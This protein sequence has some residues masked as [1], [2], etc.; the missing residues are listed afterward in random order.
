MTLNLENPES[1]LALITGGSGG[2][3]EY[4]AYEIAADGFDLVLVARTESELERVAAAAR[5]RFG[6]NVSILVFDLEEDGAADALADALGQ[7]RLVPDLVVNNAGFGLLGRAEKLS[8]E[9]QLRMI[10]LNIKVLTDLSLRYVPAM[11]KKGSGGIINVASVAGFLPGPYMSVYYAT[12]AFVNS[13]SQG[14]AYEL[15]GAGITVSSVCPGPT[16]TKFQERAGMIGRP[17]E[18]I[19][20]MM[21]AEEVAR[22]GY[23]G[24]KAGKR[25][26][27]TGAMNTL[28]SMAPR[29]MPRGFLLLVVSKLQR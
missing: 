21:S 4:L 12:K 2:I 22:I 9:E 8:R 14:L 3:G 13:F 6:V 25:L 29:F 10:N 17:V 23:R 26:A 20:K 27:V 16:A 15:K 19:S 7:R 24:Y 1:R 5:D 28:F 11:R 18:K